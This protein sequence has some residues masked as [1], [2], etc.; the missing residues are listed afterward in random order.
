MAQALQVDP[1]LMKRLK[2]FGAFDVSA[3][4][5]CGN[6]TAVCPLSSESTAFPRKMITYAQQG[7]E[8][9]LLETPDMWLCDYCAECSKTCPRQ[10]QPSEFMMAVRRFAVSK[11]SPTPLSRMLFTSKKFV[12]LF[13]AVIALIPLGLFATLRDPAGTGFNM[14]S[15]IPEE[16]IHYSGIA[17]GVAIGA[18]VVVGITRMYLRIT[19]SLRGGSGRG[20][21]V[22]GWLRALAPT[23]FKDTLLQSRSEECVTKPSLTE[24]FAGRWFNHMLIF[25]GFLGLLL[26]TG[27]RFLVVPTGGEVVP[28][29]DP[30]RLLGTVSGA[31]L[32]FGTLVLIMERARKREESMKHTLFTDWVFLALLFLAGATGFVLE[33]FDYT[34]VAAATNWALL[35]HLV[36][37]FELLILAPF[38][39]FAHAVYRPIA[40]WMSRAYNH[41]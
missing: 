37:V 7:L 34:E 33:G 21:G 22:G 16:W 13:M 10:A 4:F 1:T 8:G 17:V 29:T 2:Q 24:K 11:Y 26:S 40:I 23:V 27:L 25:W 41:V 15:V 18:F 12:A 35:A 6:C 30:V 19:P 36:V 32:A 28:L 3:C 9:K 39:K 14:F 31:A 20:P 5:N 38:T